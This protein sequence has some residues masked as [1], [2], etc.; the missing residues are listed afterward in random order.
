[1]RSCMILCATACAEDGA[2]KAVDSD[3]QLVE[4]GSRADFDLRISLGARP[5][6]RIRAPAA[7]IGMF[8]RARDEPALFEA[9]QKWIHGVGVDR[10]H[11]ARHRGDALHQSVAV[12]RTLCEQM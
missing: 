8:P 10:H 5:C 2:A 7:S 12:L 11:I 9:P 1:M 3:D 6:D 4:V